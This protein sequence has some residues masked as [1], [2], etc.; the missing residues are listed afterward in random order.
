M[1]T[2]GCFH[3]LATV[4]NAAVNT[5]LHIALQ[6]RIFKNFQVGT[7][8]RDCWVIWEL[9]SQFLEKIHSV[10]YS[11]CNNLYSQQWVTGVTFSPHPFQHL[12]LLLFLIRVILTGVRWNLIAG[13]I[14]VFPITSDA[15]HLFMYLLAICTSFL[16]KC[17]F[18]RVE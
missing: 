15:M 12:S 14:C 2:V 1:L 13:L 6:I 18:I 10:F 4:N 3:F 9:Y 8:G 16:G 5:E 7:Q 17:I 11:G